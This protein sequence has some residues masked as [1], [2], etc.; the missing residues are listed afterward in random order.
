VRFTPRVPGVLY[1]T[2]LFTDNDL[3]V[4]GTW[5]AVYLSGNGVPFRIILPFVRP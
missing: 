2:L 3:N 5:R 4:P 1:G